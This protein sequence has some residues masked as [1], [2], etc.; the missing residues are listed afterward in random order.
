MKHI[1]NLTNGGTILLKSILSTPEQFKEP[2]EVLRAAYILK[3]LELEVPQFEKDTF[4]SQF[5]DWAKQQFTTLELTEAQ[6]DLVK[7][8]LRKCADKIIPSNIAIEVFEQFG[9]T[10]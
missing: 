2:S 5:Q 4:N 7:E 6:R 3:N 9:F 8:S 10:A 1:I